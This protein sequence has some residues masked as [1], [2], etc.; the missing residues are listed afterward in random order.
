MNSL[1]NIDKALRSQDEE[2][3]RGALA[4]LSEQSLQ[5]ARNLLFY[6]MGDQ[7]WRVRKEAVDVFVAMN[8]DEK[9][10]ELLLELLRNQENAGLRNSAA[11]AVGKIGALAAAPLIRLMEDNDEDVRK[12]VIDV[13]G[14]I[15]SPEFV[16]A[17]LSALADPDMNVASAA[18]EHLGNIGDNRAVAD[19]IKAIIN[20]DSILFRFSALAALGKLTSH[21]T[22]PAEIVRLADQDILRKSVYECLGSIGDESVMPILMQGFMS[23]Q[24]SSRNAAIT[25]WYRIFSRSSATD[26]QAFQEVLQRL[27]G[28]ETVPALIDSFDLQVPTLAEAITVLLGIIGDI[29]GAK[30]L[31]AAFASERLSGSA[32]ASLKRLGSRGMDA[33]IALYPDSD[34]IGRCAICTVVGDLAYRAGSVLIRET[35]GASSQ[36]LRSAAVTAVGKLGLTECITDIVCLLD[37]T[38]TEVRTAVIA[39]LQVL[40]RID[41]RA[42]QN[43]ARQLEGSELPEQR[44]EAV[45]LNA[46]LGDGDRLTLLVKDEN[47]TVRQAAV[48]SIGKLH[49]SSANNILLIA[50]V[51]EDPDVRIAAAE[52]LGEVGGTDVVP[53]LINALNDE[54]CWVQC[55]V[56]RSIVR[57]DKSSA[58]QTI[59]SILSTAEGLL[60]I[61]CLE[62]LEIIGSRQAIDLAEKALDSND[63]EVLSL[64]IAI[65]ARQGGEWVMSNAERLMLHPR[66]EVRTAW[67]KVL[68]E[69]PP[70]LAK[71]FLLQA[72]NREE[73]KPISIY[74]QGLLEGIA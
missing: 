13:M 2:T 49:F 29:R 44:R 28:S 45:I 72:L 70:Q 5:E 66:L 12:F 59:Q 21:M 18:A 37:D 26:R 41:R 50:L 32:L 71:G 23:R 9:S 43:V 14:I 33:L 1:P 61:T 34:E 10:I 35:L 46:T 48:T 51:D 24:K 6:A 25:G 36:Q 3:R 74:I 27:S 47:A 30:T 42:I 55:A 38:D 67:V 62:L 68:S 20:N 17:L 22:I 11:E 39:C 52:A 56:L 60:M 19:L 4:L 69:L 40:A 7:S 58:L 57:I 53:F 15:G 16:P 31:L 63:N 54:D 65:L 64:L 73:N 8:P